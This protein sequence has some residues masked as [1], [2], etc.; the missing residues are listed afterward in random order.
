ML[1]FKNKKITIL[2]GGSAIKEIMFELLIYADDITRVVPSTDNGA[3][4]KELRDCYDILS[5]GDIRQSL[6]M[7]IP[8]TQNNKQLV[9]FINWRFPVEERIS[10]DVLEQL[11]LDGK[12][13]LYQISNS[14]SIQ[15]ELFDYLS[16]FL[17]KAKEKPLNL[18]NGSIGNFILVA[19]YFKHHHDWNEAIER[20]EKL[21][22]C[23]SKVLPIYLNNHYQLKAKFHNGTVICGE[24]EISSF[25]GKRKKEI[26]SLE[27][28]LLKEH[29]FSDVEPEVNPKVLKSLAASELIVFSP[30]SFFTSILPHLSNKGVPLAL[31]NNKKAKKVFLMNLAEDEETMGYT[32]KDIIDII[33][34][35]A[36]EQGYKLSD[37]I[38]HIVIHNHYKQVSFLNRHKEKQRYIQTGNLEGCLKEGIHVIVED[39]EDPWKRGEFDAQEVVTVLHTLL[40][41]Q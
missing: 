9:K 11:L 33:H 12:S 32:A 2:S 35:L 27:I 39:L 8:H 5:V 34:N 6:A 4:S 15:K 13:V 22:G 7:S 28:A 3:S 25:C 23:N 14:L 38:T 21:F 10:I 16:L 20:L 31:F 24:S 41:E 17:E 30:G 1:N 36:K 29:K 40:E 26:E 18:S 37:F 19:A